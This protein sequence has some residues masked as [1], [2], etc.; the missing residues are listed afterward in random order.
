M[1]SLARAERVKE[2]DNDEDAMVAVEIDEEGDVVSR[3]EVLEEV[4]EEEELF[5]SSSFCS[6]SSSPPTRSNSP[7]ES[8]MYFSS[9]P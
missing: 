1:V 4:L 9:D 7:S 6:A 8:A 3:S 2:D 5:A